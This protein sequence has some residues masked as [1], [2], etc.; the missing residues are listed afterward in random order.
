MPPS[1][2]VILMSEDDSK[3]TSNGVDEDEWHLYA[4]LTMA[5]RNHLKIL[6]QVRKRKPMSSGLMVM[7]ST[8][9]ETPLTGTPP[10]PAPLGIAH[11]IKIG[12]CDHCLH[13]IGGR[14][15]QSSG[16]EGGCFTE[17]RGILKGFKSFR[18]RYTRFV[19]TM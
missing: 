15:T 2:L 6:S 8:N 4:V 3:E 11:V 1:S 18:F 5:W 12:A 9:K 10:C 17:E 19:P 7:I 14:R 16:F 13:R